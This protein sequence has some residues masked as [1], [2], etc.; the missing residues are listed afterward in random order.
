MFL[1]FDRKAIVDVLSLVQH[2]EELLPEHS[3]SPGFEERV[4]VSDQNQPIPCTRE[5]DIET[6]RGIHESNAV[7]GIRP[8]QTCDHDVTLFSL[9]IVY[10]T[11]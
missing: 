10:G 1:T 5:K 11:G 9:V 6:L 3:S 7:V 4:R 8:S 2:R